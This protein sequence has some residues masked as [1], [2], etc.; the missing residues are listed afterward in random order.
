ME[1]HTFAFGS[2]WGFVLIAVFDDRRVPALEGVSQLRS[3]LGCAG[4]TGFPPVTRC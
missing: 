1:P 2:M 3:S 4:Y